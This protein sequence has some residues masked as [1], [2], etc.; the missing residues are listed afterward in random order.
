[1]IWL[2][3]LFFSA[4]EEIYFPQIESNSPWRMVFSTILHTNFPGFSSCKATF[5]MSQHSLPGEQVFPGEIVARCDL[6]KTSSAQPIIPL[7][8]PMSGQFRRF[9]WFPGMKFRKVNELIWIIRHKNWCPGKL[10][11]GRC[12]QPF[13]AEVIIPAPGIPAETRCSMPWA[14][15]NSPTRA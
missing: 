2:L 1:V 3:H 9:L 15:Y 11:T 5:T 8:V 12:I 10:E 4:L 7:A 6:S 14:S 13:Q